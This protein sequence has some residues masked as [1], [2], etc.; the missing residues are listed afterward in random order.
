M[1]AEK[2]LLVEYGKKLLASN[3]TAG[4]GGNLSVFDPDKQLMAI[5]PSGIDY[6]DMTVDDI[7][8]MNLAGEIV[9][10]SRK[11]SSEWQMHLINYQ[12]RGKEIRSVVHAHSTYSSILAT[13]RMDLPATNYM[14]AVAGGSDV[15]CSKYA[16]FGSEKLARY[17]FEA[18]DERYACFL[19]NHGLLTCGKSLKEAFSIAEEIERLAELHYGATLLGSAVVLSEEDMADVHAQFPSYGQ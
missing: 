16:T 5:T 3:L 10:G 19:A 9:E 12:K 1:E 14:I 18:M 8:L 4:T 15:R 11:P 17:A 7:V 2:A 6:F 13:C